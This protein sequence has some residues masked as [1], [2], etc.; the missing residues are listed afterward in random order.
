MKLK[1][2]FNGADGDPDYF[3]EP[4]LAERVEEDWFPGE[5][6]RGPAWL[7]RILTGRHAGEFL[8]LT[9]RLNASL[10]DQMEVRDMLSVVV[11]LVRET[12][13]RFVETEKTMPPIAMA[14]V[15]IVN[16]D[17]STP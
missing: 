11:Q 13:S 8:A 9:S 15:E 4:F 17:P 6:E 1:L 10:E 16:D 3:G 2:A 12:G 5:L 14:V 7:V